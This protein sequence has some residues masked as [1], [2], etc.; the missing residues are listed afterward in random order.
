MRGPIAN[1][2]QQ[3]QRMQEQIK[4]AQ[5]DLAKLE[6]IGKS[7]GGLVS[8]TLN[9]RM[10]TRQVRIDPGA[11]GDPEMLEDLLAAAFNDAVNKVQEAS[12]ARM[13]DATAG[14]P[15]PPG[16]NLGGLF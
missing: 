5:E 15:L 12:R 1:L 14:M 6:V 7:G 3:A 16:M 13:A 4:Q 11:M 8:V 2:M 9:G 10:E